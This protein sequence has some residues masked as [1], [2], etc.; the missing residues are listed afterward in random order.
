MLIALFLI[1]NQEDP[2]WKQRLE[3]VSNHEGTHFHVGM[4]ALAK[5]MHHMFNLQANT[6]RTVTQ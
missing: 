5:Y 3:A 4:A 6:T 1:R 2:M